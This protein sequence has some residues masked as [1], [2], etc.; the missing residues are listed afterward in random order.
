M[1]GKN[2][3]IFKMYGFKIDFFFLEMI[4]WNDYNNYYDVRKKNCN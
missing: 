4:K 2:L 3:I 1:F